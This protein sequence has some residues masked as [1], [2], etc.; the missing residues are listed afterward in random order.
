MS[1]QPTACRGVLVARSDNL[2]CV[3]EALLLWYI[4]LLTPI[5]VTVHTLGRLRSTLDRLDPM[6]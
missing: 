3:G 2:A 4:I 5:I 1:A 6:V